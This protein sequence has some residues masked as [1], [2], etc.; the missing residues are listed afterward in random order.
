[1]TTFSH[2]VY[3]KNG[4]GVELWMPVF[5]C[6]IPTAFEVLDCTEIITRES[7]LVYLSMN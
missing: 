1:M 3:S 2:Y 7:E 6:Y 4:R 5:S